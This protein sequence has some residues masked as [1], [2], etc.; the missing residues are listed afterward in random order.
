[1]AYAR[2]VS[3]RL[4]KASKWRLYRQHRLATAAA[5]SLISLQL[6]ALLKFPKCRFQMVVLM[7]EQH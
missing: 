6:N 2:L 7:V 5:G 3:A 4:T 1:M